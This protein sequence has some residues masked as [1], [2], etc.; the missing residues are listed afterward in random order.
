MR[1]VARYLYLSFALMVL[2]S[3]AIPISRQAL[4]LGF[5]Q[6]VTQLTDQP[7][8]ATKQKFNW[9]AIL[10]ELRSLAN[11][12]QAL[13][14]SNQELQAEVARLKEVDHQ[15]EALRSELNFAK[16]QT[17]AALLASVIGRGSQG[18]SR[19]LIVNKGTRDGVASGQAVIAQGWLI[20]LVKTSSL[21]RSSIRLLDDPRSLVP[22]VSQDSRSNGLLRGGF[23]GLT[24]TDVLPDADLKIDETLVTSAL[25]DNVRAGIPVGK[26]KSVQSE[27]G[28]IDKQ[29]IIGSPIEVGRLELVFI[30]RAKS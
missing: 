17:V 24:L 3:L 19:D 13:I 30:E 8:R 26:V 22:V 23:S 18:L 12:N 6:I 2:I 21:D 28:Q 29:A 14:Q 10:K 5:G 11:Q 1:Q 27:P 7:S 16:T 9:L 15:N 25:L 4:G 20:G